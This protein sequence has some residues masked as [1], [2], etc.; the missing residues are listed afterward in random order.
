MPPH[1]QN[2]SSS[3]HQRPIIP[4]TLQNHEGLRS[5]SSCGVR[6]LPGP[7]VLLGSLLQALSHPGGMCQVL[8]ARL[9]GRRDIRQG[10]RM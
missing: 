8:S 7:G 5:R 1:F 3:L 2:R 4:A 6:G 10:G 9:Q